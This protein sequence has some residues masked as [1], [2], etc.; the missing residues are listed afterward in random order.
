MGC[1]VSISLIAIL[2]GVLFLLENAGVSKDLVETYWPIALVLL[3]LSG[4]FGILRFRWMAGRLRRR[5]PPDV[6]E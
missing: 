4:L 1:S 6:G 5:W 3:G 2:F